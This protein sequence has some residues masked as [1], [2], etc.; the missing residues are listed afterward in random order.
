MIQSIKILIKLPR[1]A[2]QFIQKYYILAVAASYAEGTRV[3]E[4][5]AISK[6]DSRRIHSLNYSTLNHFDPLNFN[7]VEK[8]REYFC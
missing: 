4:V 8:S 2:H 1:V 6:V 3:W 7:Q 5:S